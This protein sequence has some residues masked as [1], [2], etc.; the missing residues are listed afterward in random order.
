[1]EANERLRLVKELSHAR[2]TIEDLQQELEERDKTIMALE[3]VTY[4]IQSCS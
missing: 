3:D 4:T 1:M 2:E